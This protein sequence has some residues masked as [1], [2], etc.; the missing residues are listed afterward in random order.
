[1]GMVSLHTREAGIG[2]F[3]FYSEGVVFCRDNRA[4]ED[5]G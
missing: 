4:G 3:L 2:I 5:G 1:M